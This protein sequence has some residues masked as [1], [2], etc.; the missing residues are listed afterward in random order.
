MDKKLNEGIKISYPMWF[1]IFISFCGIGTILICTYYIAWVVFNGQLSSHLLR[2]LFL[3]ILILAALWF[4]LK[5]VFYSVTATDRGI[6]THNIA[7]A[8]K[9]FLWDEI[10]EIRKP[11]FGIPHDAIYLISENKD[12]LM[13]LKGMKDLD[14]FIQ[15]IKD[16]APNLKKCQM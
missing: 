7:G 3:I 2:F 5:I 8:N 11:V 15:L 13:L 16:R 10:V 4:L 6:G 14:E 12:K 1:V 9:F